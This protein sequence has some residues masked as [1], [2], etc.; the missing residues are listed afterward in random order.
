MRVK[1]SDSH[2]VIVDFEIY[3]GGKVYRYQQITYT[4]AAK[5]AYKLLGDVQEYA[6]KNVPN[7][8]TDLDSIRITKVMQ[9]V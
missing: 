5:T 4:Y 9:L 3:R 7:F 1:L 2:T 6:H 8:D